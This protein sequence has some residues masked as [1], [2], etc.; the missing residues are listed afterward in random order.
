M[1]DIG[2]HQALFDGLI[3]LN[4]PNFMIIAGRYLANAGTLR[5]LGIH[6]PKSQGEP[7]ISQVAVVFQKL[8]NTPILWDGINIPAV[9]PAGGAE[10]AWW[11]DHGNVLSERWH[12]ALARGEDEANEHTKAGKALDR[13]ERDRLIASNTYTLAYT[14]AMEHDDYA[15]VLALMNGPTAEALLLTRAVSRFTSTTPK[16]LA[17]DAKGRTL[18][19]ML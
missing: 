18:Q 6:W 14:A 13:G 12:K 11:T 5:P 3:A 9:V 16:P 7:D 2:A 8:R 17:E 10:M 19:A 4:I 1:A 15:Q